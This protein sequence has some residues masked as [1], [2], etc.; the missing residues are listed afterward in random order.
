MD[1]IMK[2]TKCLHCAE[3]IKPF[4]VLPDNEGFHRECLIRSIVGSVAHQ[5]GKCSC[6]GGNG[7][8]D[9]NLSVRENARNALA[10]FLNIQDKAKKAKFN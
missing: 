2:M 3:E 8:D 5:K 1:Q 4:E 7:E 9:K 6:N 10:Y